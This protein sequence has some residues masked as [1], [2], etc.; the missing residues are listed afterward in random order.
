MRQITPQQYEERF[1]AV[2]DIAESIL[3]GSV[4]ALLIS[5]LRAMSY[6]EL[7]R[8]AMQLSETRSIEQCLSRLS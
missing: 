6:D 4:P 8:L 7:G 3:G 1:E 2:L 5:Q